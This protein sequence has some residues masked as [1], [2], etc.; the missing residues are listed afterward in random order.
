MHIKIDLP[1]IYNRKRNIFI[2]GIVL[3]LLL[4]WAYSALLESRCENLYYVKECVNVWIPRF[5]PE[6]PMIGY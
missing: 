6:Q 5:T 1:K 3:G 4:S 2:A